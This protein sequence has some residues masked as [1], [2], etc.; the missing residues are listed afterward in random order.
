MDSSDIVESFDESFYRNDLF[1]LGVDIGDVCIDLIS[2][3]RVLDTIPVLGLLRGAYNAY[4]NIST[5]RLIKKV[6]RFLL[7]TAHIS[8]E[9]KR[10]FI[11]E[12]SE[13]IQDRGSEFLLDYLNRVD[14]IKKIDIIANIISAKVSGNISCIDLIVLCKIIE[15][16]PCSMFWS[17]QRYTTGQYIQGETD[18]LFGLGLLYISN[19]SPKANLFSLNRNGYLLLKYGLNE[20]IDIPNEYPVRNS[21]YAVLGSRKDSH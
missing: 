6:G 12:L 2:T 7:T 11:D 5:A 3:N 15:N 16:L 20:G 8:P 17:L 9:D 21:A 13:E 10:L 1:D 18:V 4:K 14:N 19:I